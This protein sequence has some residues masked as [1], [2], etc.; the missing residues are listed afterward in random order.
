MY[1]RHLSPANRLWLP[2][3]PEEVT[4]FCRAYKLFITLT[5]D[6]DDDRPKK[7]CIKGGFNMGLI[8]LY[9][10]A[11]IGGY[12]REA[13]FYGHVA[14]A[15]TYIDLPRPYWA[16]Q[17]EAQGRVIMDDLGA[18][19]AE[20]G[21]PTNAWPVELVMAGVE[22]LAGL[23]AGTWGRGHSD[24]PWAGPEHYEEIIWSLFKLWD[25]LILGSHRPVIPAALKDEKRMRAVLK[26]YFTSRNPKFQCLVHS[27]AHIGNTFLINGEPRFL[28]WQ[29]VHVGSALHDVAYFIA[30]SLTVEDR[31]EHEMRILNHYLDELNIYD[32]ASLSSQDED[33]MV[34]YRKSMLAG[35][36]WLLTPYE[37]QNEERVRAMIER[38]AMAL[39]DH[40]VIEL[41]ESLPDVE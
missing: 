4:A 34:E 39:I 14:P 5:Y 32:D 27:D 18:L 16:G 41:I 28:D 22:Q 25:D 10:E 8:E 24:Y 2:T 33:L 17:N 1:N 30:G 7:I 40:R 13:L 20:F 26:K 19:G 12:R 6:D 31:R 11:L 9:P 38:Q 36:V 15:F 21:E 37:L 35:L 29:A 3:S 23:H